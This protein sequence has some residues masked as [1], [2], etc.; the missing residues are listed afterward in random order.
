MKCIPVIYNYYYNIKN[1][2]FLGKKISMCV[3]PCSLLRHGNIKFVHSLWY[4]FSWT[5]IIPAGWS[6]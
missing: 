5:D 6:Y 2:K 1:F 4:A 3:P